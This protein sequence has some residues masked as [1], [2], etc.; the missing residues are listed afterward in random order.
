MDIRAILVDFG[1]VYMEGDF[2][3]FI[4]RA[5]QYLGLSKEGEMFDPVCQVPELNRGAATT[6]ESF[7]KIFGVALTD[8]QYARLEQ[9]WTTTWTILPGMYD[10]MLRLRERFTLCIFSNSDP[11]NTPNYRDKGWHQP[12]HHEILSHE[13]GLLKPDRAIFDLALARVGFAAEQCL[14]IDDQ[15]ANILAARKLGLKTIQFSSFEQ[16]LVDLGKI[17]IL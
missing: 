4:S 6:R 13:V 5:S 1:G 15:P 8:E 3:T 14:L 12:F 16:L 17:G 10:L 11:V 9:F 7:S 2:L